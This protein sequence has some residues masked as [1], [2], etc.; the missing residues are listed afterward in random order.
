[1]CDALPHI[2][3]S[4]QPAAVPL[5]T[6]SSMATFSCSFPPTANQLNSGFF[7]CA[8]TTH[9]LIVGCCCLMWCVS[10]SASELGHFCSAA[11]FACFCPWFLIWNYQF[12]RYPFIIFCLY[13]AA[14]NFQ[15][16]PIKYRELFPL[17]GIVK[18]KNPISQSKS[19]I[20]NHKKFVAG[21]LQF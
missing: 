19:D 15:F 2:F 4:R 5:H 16:N 9:I 8:Y 17:P 3:P 21:I 6:N 12:S 20:N 18:Q 10:T 11:C 7:L 1:M 14:R 13:W